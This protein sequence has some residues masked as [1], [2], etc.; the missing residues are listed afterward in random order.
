MG[1]DYYSIVRHDAIA[2]M[3]QRSHQRVLE[4]GCGE[5]YTL[6]YLK[7]NGYASQV[8]GIELEQSCFGAARRNTDLFL[9]GDAESVSLREIGTYDAVL[10][11]DVL[12]HLLNPYDVLKDA[13]NLLNPGGY[14]V[15]SI[16]NIRNLAML[17]RLVLQG[18]WDYEDSG[19]LDRGHLR[20]FT[21]K[22]FLKNVKSLCPILVLESVRVKSNQNSPLSRLLTRIPFLGDFF[23]CQYIIRYRL[24][25]PGIA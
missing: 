5:G 9:A 22:S 1:N 13:A 20:F 19:I 16:P 14:L 12:E 17:K 11:L 25:I 23:T 18:L 3:D 15:I 4:I 24:D 8:T 10:L 7:D 2:M 6:R 21:R